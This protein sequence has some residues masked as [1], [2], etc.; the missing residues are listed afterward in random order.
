MS[1][2]QNQNEKRRVTTF[3]KPELLQIFLPLVFAF[4]SGFLMHDRDIS[5]L[6][7]EVAK[8]SE[9]VR[10][11]T[12]EIK[13]VSQVLGELVVLRERVT[14]IEGA[15][16]LSSEIG[17]LVQSLQ[18]QTEFSKEQLKELQSRVRDL[19]RQVDKLSK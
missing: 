5:S 8:F 3:F 15:Q 12:T 19:E 2:E 10:D 6:K 13:S 1:E 7:T 18:Q 14:R 16:S 9:D 11:H 17:V 4:G